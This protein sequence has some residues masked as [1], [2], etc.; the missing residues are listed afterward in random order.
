MSA[1]DEA[2]GYMID[3]EAADP[4][5]VDDRDCGLL[6]DA[7]P[8]TVLAMLAIERGGLIEV[9]SDDDGA[10]FDAGTGDWATGPIY[11]VGP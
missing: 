5:E 4:L 1:R 10:I 7:I 9:R 2:I 6:L 11:R 3:I 8:A